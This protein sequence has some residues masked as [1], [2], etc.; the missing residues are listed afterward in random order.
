M[1]NV[2][3]SGKRFHLLVS[4]FPLAALL[5]IYTVENV[6]THS[7]YHDPQNLEIMK[8]FGT[9][10]SGIGLSVLF[11]ISYIAGVVFADLAGTAWLGIMAKMGEGFE[12]KVLCDPTENER[13][14]HLIILTM[15]LAVLFCT[16]YSLLAHYVYRAYFEGAL[17][18]FV[19]YAMAGLIIL[20]LLVK[21]IRRMLTKQNACQV[22]RKGEENAKEGKY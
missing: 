18:C 3:L 10:I 8:A 6:T 22:T 4:G 5:G 14:N 12:N 2:L 7:L 15:M 16:L 21:P 19:L 13:K 1:S 20:Y 9:L 11:F 17:L